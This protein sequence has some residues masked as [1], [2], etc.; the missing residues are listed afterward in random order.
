VSFRYLDQSARF[1][2]TRRVAAVKRPYLEMATG[3]V[4]PGWHEDLR[5]GESTV[6][7][8][9]VYGLTERLTLHA[10]VP[11]LANRFSEGGDL[12]CQA[13][14]RASG[15]GDAV[16]GVRRT[17]GFGD[18]RLTVGTALKLPTGDFRRVHPIGAAIL[19]PMLQ[20][21]SGSL[22]F[23]GSVALSI[24]TTPRLRLSAS[25]SHQVTGSNALAYRFGLET[26]A[27]V[28]AGRRLGRTTVTLQGK[29]VHRGRSTFHGSPAA[30]TG[31]TVAYAVPTV[32]IAGPRGAGVYLIAPIPVFRALRDAQLA[33][34]WGLVAGVSTTFGLR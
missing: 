28:T 7:L 13:L 24:V 3:F 2:G 12:L 15:L 33:P 4:Y 27:G 19:E 18:R 20:P 23:L 14:S 22:D 25:A 8:G 32:Q 5:A 29:L 26:I 9:V 30:S 21:G 17:F 11:V 1:E 31:S 6:Q 34:S 10:S 16:V